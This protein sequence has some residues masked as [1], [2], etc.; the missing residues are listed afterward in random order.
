MRRGNARERSWE[1]VGIYDVFRNKSDYG[2]K[3][4]FRGIIEEYN[5]YSEK[6]R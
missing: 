5:P 1:N 2:D 6:E 3:K 4:S